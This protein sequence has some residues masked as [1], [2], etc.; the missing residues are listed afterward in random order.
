MDQLISTY[1]YCECLIHAFVYV[2]SHGPW[3]SH[4]LLFCYVSVFGIGYI[5]CEGKVEG[6]EGVTC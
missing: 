6:E 3:N 2:L 1:E 5:F 4:N